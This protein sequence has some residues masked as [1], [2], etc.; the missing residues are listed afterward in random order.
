MKRNSFFRIL[1]VII[2]LAASSPCRAQDA[3]EEFPDAG[4]FVG[5]YTLIGK[6]LEGDGTFMGLLVLEA[7]STGSRSF[8]RIIGADTIAGTWGIE[9][10]I[11][12]E[13]RVVR[14]RWQ[15]DNRKFECT[16]QWCAD[17]DSYPRLS[18]HCYETGMG[19]DSPG[20]EVGFA[21]WP[22]WP[23]ADEDTD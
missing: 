21:I 12:A 23:D 5:S 6:V 7:D 4:F 9:Y 8:Q 3:E 16:Y 18:G 20:M 19:T 13:V 17:F 2:I 14:I 15:R 11:G 1:P 22:E 10:A